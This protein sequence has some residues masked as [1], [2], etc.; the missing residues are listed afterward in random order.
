MEPLKLDDEGRWW[1][2]A[3][4]DIDLRTESTD[5]FLIVHAAILAFRDKTTSED[6]DISDLLLWTIEEHPPWTGECAS[7]GSPCSTLGRSEYVAVEW[8]TAQS[9]ALIERSQASL[10]R[11]E[12]S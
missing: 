12:A 3:G 2:L 8:L 1:R 6:E 9:R 7:C 10:A 5:G 4:H 11:R